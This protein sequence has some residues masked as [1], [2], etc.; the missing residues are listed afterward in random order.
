MISLDPQVE[1]YDTIVRRGE[2]CVDSMIQ[3]REGEKEKDSIY[4]QRMIGENLDASPLWVTCH[5]I[6]N[7]VCCMRTC[8]VSL[9]SV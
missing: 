3:W 5:R 8:I 7:T 2:P 1:L 4:L 6:C 9:S